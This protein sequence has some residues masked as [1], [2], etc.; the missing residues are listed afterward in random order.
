MRTR[1]PLA[2][3]VPIA[4]FL[5]ASITMRQAAAT[6]KPTEP[7]AKP[8]HEHPATETATAAP[9]PTGSAA[10]PAASGA[11][12]G[13]EP[14]MVRPTAPG[15]REGSHEQRLE[16]LTK[17]IAERQSTI[18]ARRKAEQDETRVRWGKVVDQPP[19]VAELKTH[20]E[21]VARLQRIQEL[22]EVE[23]K[24]AVVARAGRALATE[25]ARHEKQ[26]QTLAGGAK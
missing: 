22:A 11:S 3:A 6:P 12:A 18:D 21:R 16:A 24:P 17:L 10:S 7:P 25:N 8:K 14:A 23:S 15:L 9:K 26:M 5:V 1:M 19:V 4:A 13:T 20:A 2:S